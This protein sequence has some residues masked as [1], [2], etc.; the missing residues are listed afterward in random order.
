MDPSSSNFNDPDVSE[1]LQEFA[2]QGWRIQEI[3]YTEA[4][5]PT[6]PMALGG[7]TFL[8]GLAACV[9]TN[10]M[11][12]LYLAVGG[13]A[14]GFGMCLVLAK[15]KRRGWVKVEAICEDREMRRAGVRKDRRWDFRLLCRFQFQGVDCS[16]TPDYWHK[17]LSEKSLTR[18]LDRHIGADGRCWLY[19]NPKEP[20]QADFAAGGMFDAL[21]H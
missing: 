12:Y 8:G 7:L 13:W 15:V 3:P 21:F 5:Q 16:A 4:A 9:L 18:F 1:T 19:V 14:F 2:G 11:S 10:K 6:W 20:R 17:F